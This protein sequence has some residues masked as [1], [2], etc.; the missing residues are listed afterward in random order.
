MGLSTYKVPKELFATNRKKLCSEFQKI[1]K[2]QEEHK[3]IVEYFCYLEGGC[4]ATR[5]DSDHEPIFRQESY[6]HYLFGV[7]EPDWAG[8]IDLRTGKT[9]MF[10]PKLPSEYATF[11]GKIK[12]PEDFLIEYQVDEVKYTDDVEDHFLQYENYKILLLKGTNSDSGKEFI[13]PIF[14]TKEIMD[15][16]DTTSLFPILAECRVIKSQHELD[17][18]R[19]CTEITS[20]AHVFTMKNTKVGMMEY[21]SESLFRHY[22]YYNFGARHVRSFFVNQ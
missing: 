16:V 9:T 5:N 20:L 1:E 17:L 19:Y 4:S 18:M 13:P 7:K 15:S 8:C 12:Q 11:M 22:A 14:K 3:G 6:F 10:M 21:Q 2:H